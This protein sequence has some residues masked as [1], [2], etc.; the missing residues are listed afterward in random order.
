M[1]IPTIVNFG[2]STVTCGPKM[3]R[4]NEQTTLYTKKLQNMDLQISDLK[5]RPSGDCLTGKGTTFSFNVYKEYVNTYT[6]IDDINHN[7]KKVA[8]DIPSDTAER[9]RNIFAGEGN[10]SGGDTPIAQLELEYSVNSYDSYRF[11]IHLP[12]KIPCTTLGT[13]VLCDG[14]PQTTK[15]QQILTSEPIQI[16]HF[17]GSYSSELL[18]KKKE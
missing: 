3:N 1:V 2:I 8:I 11:T 16:I 12:D 17:T 9:P 15:V 7:L 13:E 14:I 4:I 5:V 6:A 10:A 18:D